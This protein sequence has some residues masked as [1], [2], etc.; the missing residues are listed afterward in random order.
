[1]Q[2]M[3]KDPLA[4]TSRGL[5]WLMHASLVVI[6]AKKGFQTTPWLTWLAT[7][8]AKPSWWNEGCTITLLQIYCSWFLEGTSVFNQWK[9]VVADI[10]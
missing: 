10:D 7:Q 9:E 8:N 6:L 2:M 3:P 1:L 5:Y 4:I